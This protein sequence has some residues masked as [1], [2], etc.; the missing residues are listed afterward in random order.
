MRFEPP[1]TRARFIR[2][3]KRF[4]VDATVK[5]ELV[6]AHS[7]NTGSLRGCL[8]EGAGALLAPADNPARK[9]RWTFRAIEVD[10]VWVGVDTSMAVPAVEEALDGGLLEELRP[11]D[12]RVREVKY[13]REG[14]S[15]ID[16]L[17]ST[18]GAEVPPRTRRGRPSYEGD[19]RVYVEV[20]ST[21]LVE[22]RDG[23]RVAMFP[24]AV[25]ARGL[26]HLEELADVVA[27]GYRAAMVYVVQ[28]PDADVFSPARH[29]D[30]AYAEGFTRAVAAG[31]EVYALRC[32]MSERALQPT[33]RLPIEAA[34]E[35]GT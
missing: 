18:G 31:V 19:E 17:L 23:R 9:L 28:R 5:D 33:A 16:L 7:T 20:K 13:G 1:L 27:Q 21:T 35:G 22:A 15:R 3:Y 8:E 34:S 24:D 25:T 12:R 32:E 4:L 2:R 29:I 30:P 26:K 14:K 6:V 11:Y 10:G